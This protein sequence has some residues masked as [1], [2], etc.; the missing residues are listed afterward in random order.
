MHTGGGKEHFRGLAVMRF[1]TSHEHHEIQSL[2]MMG[3][4]CTSICI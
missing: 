3:E 4:Y 1:Q 2:W